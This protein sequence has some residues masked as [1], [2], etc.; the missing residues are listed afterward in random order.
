MTPDDPARRGWDLVAAA[1]AGSS[2]AFG[3]LW[4]L[5]RP[6]VQRFIANRVHNG[7]LAEDLTSETFLRA[8]R[9]LDTVRYEGADVGA[10]LLRIA[11][12]LVIDQSRR[13]AGKVVLTSYA[14]DGDDGWLPPVEGPDQTV[15]DKVDHLAGTDLMGRYLARLTPH[16]QRCLR[17][18]FD[19]G[20][21]HS[22]VGAAL[23]GNEHVSREARHRAMC[24]LRTLLARDGYRTYADVVARHPARLGGAA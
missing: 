14:E 13:P 2:A 21:T 17:L 11:R 6:K 16:Q 18:L 22:E 10:W 24:K 9:R 12:N 15:P 1:Q 4:T 3:E 5:Y 7:H 8:L 19:L 23:G 20:L